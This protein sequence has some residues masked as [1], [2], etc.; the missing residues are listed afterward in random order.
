MFVITDKQKHTIDVDKHQQQLLEMRG[1]HH[2]TC[3]VCSTL[4]SCGL[5]AEFLVCEDGRVETSVICGKTNEGY[6]G[7]V[8]GGVIASLLDGAMTNC[9]FSLGIAA[10]TGEMTTRMLRPVP[11]QEPVVV[12]AW[13]EKNRAPLYV[14][15]AEISHNGHISARAKGKFVRKP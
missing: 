15:T 3:P 13:L 11:P 9:L 8:H 4:N 14:L 7:F 1:R 12:R 2:E 6:E 10:V 5:N